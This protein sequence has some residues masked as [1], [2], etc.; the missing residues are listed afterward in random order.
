MA[1]IEAS[2]QSLQFMTF[3]GLDELLH[4]PQKHFKSN[5]IKVCQATK[6]SL[7]L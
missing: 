7:R 3:K 1:Y 5:M 6:N 4:C 2:V